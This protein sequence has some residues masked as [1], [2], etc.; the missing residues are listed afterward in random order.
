MQSHLNFKAGW[1]Y[2][3]IIIFL[4]FIALIKYDDKEVYFLRYKKSNSSLILAKFF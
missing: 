2:F 1:L 3:H 4:E